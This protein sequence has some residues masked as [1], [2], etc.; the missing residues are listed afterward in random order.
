M[1][2]YSYIIVRDNGTAPHP[3]HG[4]CTLAKCKPLIRQV[5]EPG[6]IIAGTGSKINGLGNHLVYMMKVDEILSH[7]EYYVDPRFTNRIDNYKRDDPRIPK[8]LI[9]KPF[10]YWGKSAIQ[11]PRHLSRICMNGPGHKSNFDKDFVIAFLIWADTNA[12]SAEQKSWV[13]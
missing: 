11:I 6:D 9:G 10:I 4:F 12:E 8:V 7:D 3:L 5:A 13:A 2:L 1:K